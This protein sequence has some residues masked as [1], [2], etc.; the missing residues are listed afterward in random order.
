MGQECAAESVQRIL[1]RMATAFRVIPVLDLKGG[2]VVWAQGG[3]RDDYRPL[4]SPLCPDPDPVDVVTRLRGLYPFGTFYI[5]DLDAIEGRGDHDAVI[6]DLRDR[7][8]DATFWVDRGLPDAAAL[9]SWLAQGIGHAVLGSESLTSIDALSALSVEQRETR[10]VLSLDFRGDAF[11]GSTE[12]LDRPSLWPRRVIA[13]TLA[14]VGGA[15]G[16]DSDRWAGLRARTPD[17]DL[18]AAGGVRGID[19]LT[20]LRDAGVAGALIA[21]ALHRGTVTRRDL[22][23]LNEDG[24]A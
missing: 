24:A 2:V 22:A 18:F 4:R 23:A 9:T 21:T 3:R 8:P 7:I 10:V 6:T 14:R 11:L 13:M 19:D 20:R 1:P 5:A 16:P 17:H 15:G 12:I